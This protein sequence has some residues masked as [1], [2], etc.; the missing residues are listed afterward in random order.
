MVNITVS[1]IVRVYHVYK[2]IWNAEVHKELRCEMEVGNH[3]DTFAV[4]LKNGTVMVDHISYYVY[5]QYI[6]SLYSKVV[7]SN[8]QWQETGDIHQICL[9]GALSIF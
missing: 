2:E 3:S 5:R 6:R 8:M 1:A 9:K 4:A 7:I